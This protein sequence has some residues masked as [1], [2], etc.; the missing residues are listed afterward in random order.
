MIGADVQG[1]QLLS[2]TLAQYG[3][4]MVLE[5]TDG[6]GAARPILRHMHQR[7]MD[8]PR[9]RRPHVRSRGWRTV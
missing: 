1:S 2:E 6:A 4:A 5:K 3:A 7:Y 9:T 8:G